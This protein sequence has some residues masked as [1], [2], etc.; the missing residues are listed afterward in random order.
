MTRI[1]CTLDFVNAMRGGLP[2]YL[3][4]CSLWKS[5]KHTF[6]LLITRWVGWDSIISIVTCY[7]LDSLGIESWW[8]RDFLHPS[9]PALG[10][11]QPP[12][13]WATG[14]SRGKAAGSC[15]HPQL[16]LR[17]EGILWAFMAYSR[18][19]CNSFLT[20]WKICEYGEYQLWF[21]IHISNLQH[22]GYYKYAIL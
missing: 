20:R 9:R 4:H 6:P 22:S 15:T 10:P 21:R 7:R 5:L 18:V 14:H 1:I 11:T 19:N 2:S 13:Q 12:V 16:A 3:G 17:L 8:G